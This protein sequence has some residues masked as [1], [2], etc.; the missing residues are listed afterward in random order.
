MEMGQERKPMNATK[1]PMVIAAI[2]A[3]TAMLLTSCECPLLVPEIAVELS[4]LTLCQEWDIE[5]EPVVLPDVIPP[6]ET[7]VCIC[8]HLETNHDVLLQVIWA[9][10]GDIL[11]AH[12]Q[13]F[14]SGPLLSCIGREE[15]FEPGSYRVTVLMGKTDLGH[16]DFSVDEER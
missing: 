3:I 2:I 5:G 9:G 10:R 13:V 1:P 4:D 6:D 14:V 15:G 7:Q 16:L 11:L 12:R 8:G